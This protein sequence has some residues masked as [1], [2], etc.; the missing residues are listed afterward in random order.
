[1][2]IYDITQ[3][4]FTSVVYPGDPSPS[5]ERVCDIGKGDPCNLT[6]FSMCAH[7]GTHVDAPCH[8]IADG[9][10]VEALDLS[11]T[12]GYAYVASAVGELSDA[13]AKR[14]FD[15]A[16]RS[17][18]GAGRR[19]LLKGECTVTPDAAREWRRLGVQL[20]GVESQSVGPSDAPMEVHKI[21]LSAEVVLLEGIRLGE[22]S[23]GVYFLFSAPL[24]LGG[25]DGA[26]VRAVLIDKE[27]F[28]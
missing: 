13:D 10:T 19:I 4:V 2:K 3:E 7:N 8:F 26:P 22:V 12:V 25:A 18:I 14:I 6:A 15:A 16:E 20:I 1:M 9:K 28:E 17:H 21:L 5:F 23:E 27:D 11:K 24:A